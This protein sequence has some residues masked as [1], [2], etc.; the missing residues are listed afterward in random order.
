MEEKSVSHTSI[1]WDIVGKNTG[2]SYVICNK[3][4]KAVDVDRSISNNVH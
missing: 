3:R 4:S 2:S 1:V